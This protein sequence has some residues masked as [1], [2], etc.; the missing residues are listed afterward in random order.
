MRRVV[1]EG[2]REG[3][4]EKVKRK[5]RG[6]GG[7]GVKGDERREGGGRWEKQ[8]EKVDRVEVK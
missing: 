1:D 6:R 5:S 7:D 8:R 4:G 3:E 2:E